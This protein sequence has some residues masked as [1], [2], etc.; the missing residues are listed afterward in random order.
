MRDPKVILRRSI[1]A[2]IINA[3]SSTKNADTARDPEVHQ[4]KKGN[5]WYF[6]MKAH[7]GVDSY[8]KLIHAAVIRRHAP[9]ARDFV[10]RRYHHC[11]VVDEV[12]RAK[13]RTKSEVRA[14]VEYPIGIIKR[15]FGSPRC[16]IAGLNRPLIAYS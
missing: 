10:N 14:E 8:S 4:T 5:Q 15:M 9:R 7:L 3:P 6:G 12:E 16:A 13:N 2:I 11:G 1:G